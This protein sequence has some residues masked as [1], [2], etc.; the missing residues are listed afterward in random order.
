L[1]IIWYLL[2]FHGYRLSRCG[3]ELR[4]AC[5]LLTKVSAVVPLRR[6]QFISVHRPW[7][8][9]WMGYASIRIE[10]AGGSGTD[11]EDPASTVSR[12]WFAPVLPE[13][14]VS[15]L[16]GE[17]RDGLDWDESAVDWKP[18]A[19][20]A[21]KRMLRLAVIQSLLFAAVGLAAWR[22][23]GWTAGLVVLPI[24]VAWAVRRSRS[25]RYAR[26]DFGVSY[27]S[28]VLN[29]KLSLT[30]FEKIQ[31]LSIDQSPFDRRWKMATLSIDTAAAGPAEHKIVIPYLDEAFAREEFD[32]LRA[33]AASRQ[34]I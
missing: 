2:R 4:I 16:L 20:K 11:K 24:L 27:R 19:P 26:T 22:P 9:R 29:R 3:N 12:R 30:F 13:H 15:E 6:I 1:G 28:G 14:R 5:G 34:R 32:H 25:V 18:L 33:D 31:T 7:I 17:L 10:T 8:L 23:W 21:G